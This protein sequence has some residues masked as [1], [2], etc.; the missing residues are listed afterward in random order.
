MGSFF[1][2][3]KGILPFILLVASGLGNTSMRNTSF[4]DSDYNP[5]C[6]MPVITASSGVTVADAYTTFGTAT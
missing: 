4:L 1:V 2:R 6:S 3:M 5:P